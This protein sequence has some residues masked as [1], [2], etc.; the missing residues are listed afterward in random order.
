[1]VVNPRK[2]ETRSEF[3][4][5][6]VPIEVDA[7][8]PQK[9]AVAICF[10]VWRRSRRE[11]GAYMDVTISGK[12]HE[13]LVLDNQADWELGM[14]HPDVTDGVIM[15]FPGNKSVE[16]TM[17]GM[18]TPLDVFYL[19]DNWEIKETVK[20]VIYEHDCCGLRNDEPYRMIIEIPSE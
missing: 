4:S 6:C 5:R 12:K 16:L 2:D 7:G 10:D 14:N 15:I 1:M 17:K 18:K 20:N 13:L 11:N 9:Q 19:N 3:V 8:K